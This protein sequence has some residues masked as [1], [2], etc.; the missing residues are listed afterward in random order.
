MRPV[1]IIAMVLLAA[2]PLSAGT[3]A[4]EKQLVEHID[5]H[6]AEALTFLEEVVNVNSGTMNPAGV[7]AI[8]D[9]FAPLQCITVWIVMK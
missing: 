1:A 4:V 7:R 5:A 8:A 9:I 2:T 6:R 3:D